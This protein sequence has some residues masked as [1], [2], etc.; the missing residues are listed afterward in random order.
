MMMIM[1]IIIEQ[2]A[3]ASCGS[4]PDRGDS[5][6]INRTRRPELLDPSCLRLRHVLSSPPFRPATAGLLRRG[7][8]R[9][10]RR[11][12]ALCQGAGR[13]PG[14]ALPGPS[15]VD[16]F[17]IIVVGITDVLKIKTFR[18]LSVDQRFRVCRACG[19]RCLSRKRWR[20]TNRP[21]GSLVRLQQL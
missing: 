12:T 18:G 9:R 21:A 15:D 1:I 17:N 2:H 7:D 20:E 10:R 4:G 14:P 16:Y 6:S 3:P 19:L 8:R 13:F 11:E 5:S